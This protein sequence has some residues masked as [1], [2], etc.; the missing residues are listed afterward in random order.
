MLRRF[1]IKQEQN[2]GQFLM[3][4]LKTCNVQDGYTVE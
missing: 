1:L 2:I 3:I 4:L